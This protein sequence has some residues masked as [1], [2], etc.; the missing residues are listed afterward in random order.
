MT[1]NCNYDRDLLVIDTETTGVEG[2]HVICQWGSILL[3]RQTL[4][5]K[6]RFQ[7]LVRINSGDAGRASPEAL[8][9]HGIPLKKLMDPNHTMKFQ[10][11]PEAI[12]EAHGDP[13]GYH[14]YGVHI[15]F[16]TFKLARMCNKYKIEYPF[17]D[18]RPISCRTY[19]LQAFW[20]AIGAT[21]GLGWGNCALRGMARH[22][23]IP[24]PEDHDALNDCEIT[25]EVQ[26]RVMKMIQ[27]KGLIIPTSPECPK[28]KGHMLLKTNGKTGHQFWGCAKY[29][30]CKKTRNIK[31]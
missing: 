13:Q 30:V 4:K 16:D 8:A 2:H 25:A 7:T 3:D 19:D 1:P 28:C 27:P 26:R 14:I 21:L 15:H 22:W 23:K 5:E 17:P 18:A 11:L 20:H 10:D 9:I 31:Q 24:F 29:P 6:S 12:R